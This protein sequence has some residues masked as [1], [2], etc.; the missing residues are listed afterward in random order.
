MN[1]QVST[2]DGLLA[3]YTLSFIRTGVKDRLSQSYQQA[4]FLHHGPGMIHQSQLILWQ[5]PL[6]HAL[7]RLGGGQSFR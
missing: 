1:I 4:L 3:P 2:C 6:L 7:A 5:D